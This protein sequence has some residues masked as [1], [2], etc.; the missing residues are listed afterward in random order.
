LLGRRRRVFDDEQRPGWSR[1]PIARGLSRF[2]VADV[3]TTQNAA[4]LTTNCATMSSPSPTR[5]KTVAP[6]AAS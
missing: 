2:I 3:A 4:S 6:N 5:L 1:L